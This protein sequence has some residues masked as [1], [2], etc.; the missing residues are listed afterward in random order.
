MAA[1]LSTLFFIL[2]LRPT[3]SADRQLY[4]RHGILSLLTVRASIA[5]PS[6]LEA[7]RRVKRVPLRTGRVFSMVAWAVSE[8]PDIV[9]LVVYEVNTDELVK[10]AS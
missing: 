1:P 7:R 5:D 3:D 6:D 8:G 9:T 10:R 4:D 2:Q